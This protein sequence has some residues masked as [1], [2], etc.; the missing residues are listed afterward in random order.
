[1]AFKN[2]AGLGVKNFYGT[3][4]ANEGVMGGIQVQGSDNELT[5]DISGKGIQDNIELLNTYL[6]KGAKVT[7]AI[8]EVKEAFVVTGTNPVLAIGTNGSETTNGIE[9]TEAQLESEGTY[10]LTTFDGTWAN[11]LAADTEVGLALGGANAAV[12]DAGRVRMTVHFTK[13]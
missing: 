3:R 13:L 6:P 9:L 4:T 8:A 11:G 1:M 5:F 7:K 2:E 12:T 10:E